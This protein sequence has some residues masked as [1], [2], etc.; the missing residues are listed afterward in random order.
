MSKNNQNETENK[1]FALEEIMSINVDNLREKQYKAFKKHVLKILDKIS[2]VI[3]NDG[4]LEEVVKMLD[5]SPAGD[6]YGTDN[7]YI[8]FGFESQ[9]EHQRDMDIGDT[10]RLLSELRGDKKTL[11]LPVDKL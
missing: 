8:Q 4:D 7:N 2:N 10:C 6:G 1:D 5:C 11:K 9:D 3:R